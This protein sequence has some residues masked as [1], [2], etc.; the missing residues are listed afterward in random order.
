M[1]TASGRDQRM[2]KRKHSA[3]RPSEYYRPLTGSEGLGSDKLTWYYRLEF[4][5]AL[6]HIA[7]EVLDDLNKA[8]LPVFSASIHD[9]F[10]ANGVVTSQDG[11]LQ[12]LRNFTSLE[13]LLESHEECVIAAAFAIRSWMTRWNLGAAWVGGMALRTVRTAVWRPW[14]EPQLLPLERIEPIEH[15]TLPAD[16][17]VNT[18]SLLEKGPFGSL[19]DAGIPFTADLPSWDPLRQTRED[20]E[21]EARSAFEAALDKYVS[22]LT[23]IADS[24]GYLPYPNRRVVGERMAWLVMWQVKGLSAGQI[25]EACGQE[26][27]VI[28]RAISECISLIGLPRRKASK[29]GR[30]PKHASM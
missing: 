13:R 8:C 6:E 29:P 12:V 27:R 21:L 24:S 5:E 28:E 15:F 11:Q 3:Y 9:L 14:R 20:F 30:K 4:L 10:T 16:A 7:P 1:S 19:H 18:M 22:T 26:R 25:A 17:L 23:G 2:T